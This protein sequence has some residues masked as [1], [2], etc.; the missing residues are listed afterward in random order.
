MRL[1]QTTLQA[2]L[3]NIPEGK[4]GVRETLRLMSKLV[5]QGKSNISIRT[6]AGQLTKNL[7]QKNF[8]GEID[9]IH[10]F[11]QNEIRYVKDIRNVETIQ[12]PIVTLN[13]RYGDCDDKSTLTAAL[14]ESIGHPTRFVACGFNGKDPSHVFVQTVFNNRWLS[15]ETT[16]P[17]KLGWTPPNITIKMI[18]NN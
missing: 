18:E 17:V 8:Y 11:V 7:P 4:D 1:G 14:L 10:R 5:K 6:L 15:V 9:A 13:N 3:H 16:E 2:T 12:T